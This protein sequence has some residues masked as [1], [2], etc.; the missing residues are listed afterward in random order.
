MMVQKPEVIVKM[1]QRFV[2]LS[3]G[4][5]M[6]ERSTHSTNGPMS[7]DN[8]QEENAVAAPKQLVELLDAEQDQEYVFMQ[9]GEDADFGTTM[10]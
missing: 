8:L 1:Q 10:T 2:G 4:L 3:F 5:Q 6:Q 9:R 7:A